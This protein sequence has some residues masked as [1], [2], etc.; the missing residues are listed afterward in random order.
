MK[1]FLEQFLSAELMQS[2]EEAY[3]AKNPKAEG[4]PEY[5]SK[6]RLDEE[7]TKRK[8]AETNAASVQKELDNIPKDWK[9][10]LDAKDTEIATLK[11]DHAAELE[12]AK[13]DANVDLEIYKAKGRNVTA[14]RALIDSTKDINEELTRL[15]TSDPYLFGNSRAKGTG[16]DDGSD[17]NT[18]DEGL[19]EAKMRAAVGI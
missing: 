3:K 18:G 17:D 14:I 2:V 15:K 1:K 4:L 13:K 6:Q 12:K 19:S 8:T 5:I 9:T 10:Q 7:I 11:N 16:K